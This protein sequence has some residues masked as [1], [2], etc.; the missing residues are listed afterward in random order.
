MSSFK[1]DRTAFRHQ[2]ID[3]EN[4]TKIFRDASFKERLQI[5]YYLNTVAYGFANGQFPP[6]D[7]ACF[8]IRKR[9]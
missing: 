3:Q 5:A 9:A 6:M 2:S 8:Q 7:K 4:K 1:L